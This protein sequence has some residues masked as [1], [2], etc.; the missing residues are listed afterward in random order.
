[1]A[2][3][4]AMHKRR[5]SAK[6]ETHFTLPG[7]C[8]V[9]RVLGSVKNDCHRVHRYATS[10][11]RRTYPHPR[12][13]LVGSV[14]GLYHPTEPPLRLQKFH[15]LSRAKLRHA[16]RHAPTGWHVVPGPYVLHTF[17]TSP[18]DCTWYVPATMSSGCGGVHTDTGENYILLPAAQRNDI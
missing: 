11:L 13:H 5:H 10:K 9:G 16:T 3:R 7:D 1:M 15:T 6:F 4:G 2:G 8:P 12:F 14:R 18:V 17:G